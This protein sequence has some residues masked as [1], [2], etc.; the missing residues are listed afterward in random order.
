VS[1]YPGLTLCGVIGIAVA[2]AIAAGG[3][4]VVDVN[5]LAT[6]LPLEEGDRIVTIR[7]WDSQLHAAEPRTLHDLH[8]W[9]EGLKS[10]QE[11]SA[12]QTLTLTSSLPAPRP[13][14]SAW[15]P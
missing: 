13:R 11:V 1:K 7:L 2:V 15:P 10:V 8:I 5:L 12:F 4:S 14:V 3:F 6:S 9:R